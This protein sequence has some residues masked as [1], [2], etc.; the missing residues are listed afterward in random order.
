M[1]IRIFG[2]PGTG[3]TYTLKETLGHLLGYQDATEF[4]SSYGLELPHG[5]YS[6]KD[7]VF[8]S[9]TNSAVDELIG[10]LDLKRTYS[11]GLWGTMHG[12]ALHLV[13]EKDQ[14]IREVV[15][16][17]LGKP[18]GPNWWKA[19]FA[20]S[21]GIPY[22]PDEEVS[23]LAGNQFFQ[24][25]SRAVNVYFPKYLSMGR[26]L[27][28]LAGEDEQF[29]VWGAEWLRFKKHHKIMDF[30]D[31][32]ALA[33][34]AD[35]VPDGRV[36]IAD[37]FQDFSPLQ[38]H[39]FKNWMADMEHVIIAGDD[40]QSIYLYSGASPRFMLHEFQADES[41]VLRQS[42]RL[43]SK[44]L[45]ASKTFIEFLVKDRYP[46]EFAPRGDGGKLILRDVPLTR[47]PGIAKFLAEKG[48]TV[49]ILA[50]TNGQVKAIE[51]MFILSK[52]PY[53]R[54]KTRKVQVWKDFVDR[55]LDFIK[56]LRN[57]KKTM[58]AEA[59]FYLR[60]TNL[61]PHKISP[62]AREIAKN[63]RNL[64]ALKIA[65]NPIDFIKPSKVAEFFGSERM[66][67]LALDALQV[68][69]AEGYDLPGKI[70]IDTIHAAKGREG[71]VVILFDTITKRIEQEM[72]LGGQEAFEAEARVWYVG[73]TRA[74]HALVLSRGEL[75][76]VTPKLAQ[77]H[78]LLRRKALA[79]RR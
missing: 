12:I 59:K 66:A 13:M 44:I 42:F 28:K 68:G 19:K 50:R 58:V 37:E 41:V 6:R 38:F 76:F 67:K 21:H 1:N 32:L 62:L 52:V 17:T 20:R 49:L 35:A 7:V 10:R 77:I 45:A 78:Y 39:L 43:P 53:Y 64:V 23:V 18:G 65:Q 22:D 30:D 4:L 16:N 11:S 15:S 55:I 9:H 3:K 27:D 75:P 61:S 56:A 54:F 31:M 60:F 29:G 74:R 46:K 24:S 14:Q 69:L 71:D 73:M 8:M 36:L 25:Y 40:D 34:I 33:F 51:E 57:G 2:P 79:Q 5:K 48:A 47:L 70:F 63:P 72:I 26:V